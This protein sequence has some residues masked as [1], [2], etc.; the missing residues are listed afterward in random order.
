VPSSVRR[1]CT[2][3]R[4]ARSGISPP[5]PRVRRVVSTGVVPQLCA[6]P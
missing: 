5:A 1:A 3:R 6:L 2:R 4:A